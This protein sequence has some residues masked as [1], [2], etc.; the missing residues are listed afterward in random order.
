MVLVS[1]CGGW[2]FT[3]SP[4]IAEVPTA[5]SLTGGDSNAEWEA[6]LLLAVLSVCL[7]V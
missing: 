7:S 5:T 2:T 3:I 6:G 4:V 1:S